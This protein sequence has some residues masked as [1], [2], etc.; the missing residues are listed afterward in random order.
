MN[1]L[2]ITPLAERLVIKHNCTLSTIIVYAYI[3]YR[4]WLVTRCI[5]NKYTIP[6]NLTLNLHAVNSCVF[7]IVIR[8]LSVDSRIIL[9]MHE[10]LSCQSR[11][12]FE[13]WLEY[14]KLAC[15]SFFIYQHYQLGAG[16][17]TQKAKSV[18]GVYPKPRA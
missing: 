18:Q 2:L 9:H 6:L 11:V 7:S 8:V 1:I 15:S 13:A 17:Y 12:P 3:I 5:F 4:P 10:G 14:Q 16:G